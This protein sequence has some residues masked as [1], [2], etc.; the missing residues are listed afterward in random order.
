MVL[1]NGIKRVVD[2]NKQGDK[3]VVMWVR[4]ENGIWDGFGETLIKWAVEVRNVEC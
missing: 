2:R 4:F 3:I 1:E